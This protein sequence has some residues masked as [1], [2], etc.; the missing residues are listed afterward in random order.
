MPFDQRSPQLPE[1]GVL[2]C[3]T[4]TDRR[5]DMVTLW[6][7]W[8]RGANLVKTSCKKTTEFLLQFDWKNNPR[9]MAMK[10]HIW[11]FPQ[12][13][14]IL[15]HLNCTWKKWLSSIHMATLWVFKILKKWIKKNKNIIWFQ[16][17][18]SSCLVTSPP[19]P[20]RRGPWWRDWTP[21]WSALWPSLPA[22]R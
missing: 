11:K 16:K 2:N 9:W 15:T 21:S 7:N 3:H 8:P 19:S 20:L 22:S 17:V 4:Q 1:K 13:G 18:L 5:M 10:P 14:I 12:K 6:L